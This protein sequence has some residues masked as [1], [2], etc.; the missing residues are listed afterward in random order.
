MSPEAKG[1]QAMGPEAKDLRAISA[2]L[3]LAT[4]GSRLAL[5][6]S[7]GVRGELCRLHPGLEVELLVLKT[8]GDKILDVALSQIGGKGLFTREIEEALLD[9]RAH[10]AVH[11]LK[12]L[13]TDLPEGLTVGAMPARVDPR[14]VLVCREVSSLDEL[15][16]GALIGTSSL[17]RSAQLAHYRPD[18][19]FRPIRGNVETRLAKLVSEGFDAIVLAGAGLLRL[20]LEE[21]ATQWLPTA[22]CLPAAGQ[23]II[24]VQA[25]AGDTTTLDLLAP[26]NSAASAV[27]ALAERSA[28]AALG[29]GCQ[30]PIGLLARLEGESL[31]VEGAL[32]DPSGEPCYRACVSGSAGEAR[33]LGAG[34]AKELLS[35]GR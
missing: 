15:P 4:R 1:L 17:R 16:P 27:C 3:V 25:R 14:D 23:G 12:D 29:G 5:A 33:A 28:L 31:V 9:G 7:E 10:L 19:R 2:R 32:A 13:P 8:R 35:Q 26:L 34:L 24:G 20:G 18:L 21:R 11:S 22:I 30:T 6:Q